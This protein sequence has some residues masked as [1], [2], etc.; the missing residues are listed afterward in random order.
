MCAG[1]DAG[2]GGY[3]VRVRY[4]LPLFFSFFT[5]S[6]TFWNKTHTKIRKF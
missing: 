3:I 2:G 5:E 4:A 1:Q 6:S